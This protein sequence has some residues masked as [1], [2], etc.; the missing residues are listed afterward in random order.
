MEVKLGF[1]ALP[2]FDSWKPDIRANYGGSDRKSGLIGPDGARYMVKYS[3]KQAPRGDLATSYVNNVVSEHI[4]SRIFGI[5]GYPV[6]ETIL[7]TLNG[8]VV[9]A[10]KNFIPPGGE[11][12]EFETFMRRHYDSHDIGRLPDINQIYGIL[13]NDPVL[14]PQA[15][16]FK[17]C[18]W[19][20]FVGDALVGNFDRHKGNFGYLIGEDDSVSASPVYDNGSTLYPNLSEQGMREVLAS[21]KEIMKRIKL[22]PKAA[23]EMR[24]KKVDYCDMMSSGIYNEL[25][26]AVIATVPRIRNSMPAVWEFIDECDFL[27]ETRKEFYKVMLAERMAFILEPAYLCC[28]MRQFNLGARN[29]L[30]SGADYSEIDFEKDWK[31]AQYGEGRDAADIQDRIIDSN[32]DK[33]LNNELNWKK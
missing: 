7:G 5:L 29:R 11:L 22:F 14:S 20:R 31:H 17:A 27:S 16:V 32:T 18:Y 21:P 15:D 6:H 23:L 8:E 2:S 12:L 19:E 26:S 3:E 10:C 4:S 33:N 28:I 9:V 1:A 25:T 24:G 13:E 30:E